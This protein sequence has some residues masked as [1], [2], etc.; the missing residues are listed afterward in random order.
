[1]QPFRA[2]PGTPVQGFFPRH[3]R[4]FPPPMRQVMSPRRLAA[5]VE[6]VGDRHLLIQPWSS[7]VSEW[8][9]STIKRNFWA[10]RLLVEE[11]QNHE[12]AEHSAVRARFAEEQFFC[13]FSQEAS[14][15]VVQWEM[16]ERAAYEAQF[17]FIEHKFYQ[18][19]ARERLNMED[20]D[21]HIA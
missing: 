8:S 18:N 7:S 16:T 10:E 17:R 5:M 1:M 9:L 3:P 21:T 13:H 19:V 4:G 14:Q 11:Q 20:I 6:M 15:Q 12:Q 2:L